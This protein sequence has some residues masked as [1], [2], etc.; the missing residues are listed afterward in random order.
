MKASSSVQSAYF[1]FLESLALDMRMVE[2]VLISVLRKKLRVE[3]LKEMERR[4]MDVRSLAWLSTNNCSLTEHTC[5]KETFT[6]MMEAIMMRTMMMIRMKRRKKKKEE[7]K[8][9]KKRTKKIRW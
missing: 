4:E 5:R 3:L 2:V 6:C 1:L 7:K 8:R 9:K